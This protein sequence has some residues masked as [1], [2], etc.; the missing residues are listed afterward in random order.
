M[1][2]G[3]LWLFAIPAVC[4]L[5]IAFAQFKDEVFKKKFVIDRRQRRSDGAN[6]THN[7]RYSDRRQPAAATSEATPEQ[8]QTRAT[9]SDSGV[10]EASGSHN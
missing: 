7:R 5:V 3:V 2:H 1:N 9:D 6:P 4:I 10:L 8:A